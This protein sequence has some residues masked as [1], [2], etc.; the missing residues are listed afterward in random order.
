MDF[1]FHP[2][3]KDGFKEVN[4][5]LSTLVLGDAKEV[6]L[7]HLIQLSPFNVKKKRDWKKIKKQKKNKLPLFCFL[8][9]FFKKNKT[10]KITNKS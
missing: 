10:K 4:S 7:D 2:L 8:P 3:M 9:F 5:T 6:F 1:H